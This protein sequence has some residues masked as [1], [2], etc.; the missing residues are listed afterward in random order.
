[1]PFGAGAGARPS[2]HRGGGLAGASARVRRVLP[3]WIRV[4]E[5][6]AAVTPQVD[7]QI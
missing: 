6:A 7:F 3:F 1:M 5:G 2:G 4:S